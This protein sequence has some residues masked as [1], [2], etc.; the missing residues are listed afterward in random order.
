MS[1]DI[2]TQIKAKIDTFASELE[3]LVR[4]AALEAVAGAL[5]TSGAGR[6]RPGRPA[7]KAARA[8]AAAATR[9]GGRRRRRSPQ[10]LGAAS[11]TILKHVKA[12]PGQRAEEVRAAVGMDKNLWIPAVKK[13]IED[14]KII[15]KGEKRAT[16]YTAK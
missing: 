4:Q 14:K 16:T 7:A 10:A 13:L 15:K 2:Q 8:P 11:E 3:A 9:R 5:G 6:G 12:H 1:N